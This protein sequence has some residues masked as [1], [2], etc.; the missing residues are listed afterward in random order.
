M[1]SP[2][3]MF[4]SFPSSPPLLIPAHIYHRPPFPPIMFVPD[5]HVQ[6]TSSC[7]FACFLFSATITIIFCQYTCLLVKCIQ[8]FINIRPISS[9]RSSP[10]Q[11]N[12]GPIQTSW[13]VGLDG[14][15]GPQYSLSK[16]IQG[17]S[18]RLAP[19]PQVRGNLMVFMVS[20]HGFQGS[21][22]VSHGPLLVS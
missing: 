9:F 6:S 12:H 11:H 10:P 2:P 17:F 14:N 20:C 13:A 5:V 18:Q 19:H 15:V 1:A 7:L 16:Y 8:V 4:I 22:M 3:F 21:F